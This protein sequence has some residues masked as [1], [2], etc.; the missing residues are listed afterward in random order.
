VLNG[1]IVRNDRYVAQ[2]VPSLQ[3]LEFDLV[4]HDQLILDKRD[5]RRQRKDW[6]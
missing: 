6:S 3:Q 2:V 5:I 1:V 4:S